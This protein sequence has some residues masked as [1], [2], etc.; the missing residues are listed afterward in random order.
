[1][2]QT[3]AAMGM[4]GCGITDHGS[5]SGA[6]KFYK[7]CKKVG[8]NPIVGI[9]GYFCDNSLDPHKGEKRYHIVL[10]AK[11]FKGFQSICKLMTTAWERMYYVPRMDLDMLM[12]CEDVIVSSACS[13]G[14]LTHPN[15]KRLVGIL[16][17][18]FKDDLYLEIMPLQFPQQEVTNKV[19]I[20]LSESLGVKLIATNDI[21]YLNE[22]DKKIHNFLL[23][24]NT[25][26]SLK[27]EIEGLYLKTWMEMWDT[28]QSL[29]YIDKDI[30]YSA[31]MNTHEVSDK[32]QLDIPER[33]ISL[34]RMDDVEQV[35]LE[36]LK[37]KLRYLYSDGFIDRRGYEDRLEYEFNIIEERG[38]IDYFNL[39][40]DLVKAAR[41]K[42]IELDPGRG[43]SAGSLIC[44]LLGITGL[45]PIKEGLMFER[46]LNPERIDYPDIDMDFPRSRR[47]EMIEYL[48]ER[49][50]NDRVAN[51]STVAELRPKS[52]MKDT[53]REFKIPPMLANVL[54]KM[55]DNEFDFE[56]NLIN[57]EIL[58]T[59]IESLPNGEEIIEFT[60][61]I[62]GTLR[63]FGT[64]AA[65]VVVAPDK[66]TEFGVLERR[67]EDTCLN[68]D[69][70]DVSHFG[71]V[72][73]DILGLRTLDIIAEAR[74]LIHER[75][76]VDIKW[77]DIKVDDPEIVAEFGKG[78]T[79]G[80]FQ[81]E[82]RNMTYLLKKLYPITTKTTLIDCNALGRPGP[83]DSGMVDSY[84][85]R[86]KEEPIHPES[87]DGYIG[88]ITVD[89]YGII[90]YQEQIIQILCDL[91]G[92]T[93]PQADIIRRIFAK[94]KGD[95][96]E[97]RD[98]FINGCSTTVGMPND[99]ANHLFDH[100][101][102]FSRYGFN[103]SHAAAYTELAL[104]QMWLKINYPIEYMIALY[105]WTE[106]EE[107]VSTFIDECQR[108]NIGIYS[109]DINMSQGDFSILKENIII[110][111][112]AIKGVGNVAVE[113]I[114]EERNKK[115][116]KSL[117]D[118]RI[119]IPKRKANISVMKALVLSG[120]FDNLEE[121]NHK[122]IA[123]FGSDPIPGS[124]DFTDEEKE[125]NKITLMPGIYRPPI[126]P[127]GGLDID[128][129]KLDTL[130]G[131][132]E[133]CDVCKL[134]EAYDKP[135]P[136]EFTEQSKI[137]VVAEAPG[138]DEW[139]QGRP[140]IGK[141]GQ[142]VEKLF[143][144]H[145]ITR[146]ELY[147]TNVFKCRPWSNKL[148]DNCPRD[149]YM[150]LEKEI[151]MT[152]PKMILSLGGTPM[153]F[154]T[155]SKQGIEGRADKLK[156]SLEVIDGKTLVNVLY[157]VHPASLFYGNG[158]A[159][160]KRLEDSIAL[161]AEVYFG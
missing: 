96:E 23:K 102:T 126:P 82:S 40:Y 2:V 87:Y 22:E 86:Y 114:I 19:A 139:R 9:E 148:P 76:G 129:Y 100:L 159:N 64:H 107:K 128:T 97:H 161:I 58:R 84:V 106:E 94:K 35:T 66:I 36:M 79:A 67:K 134:R 108:M 63:Q 75:H 70:N 65:G 145:G 51:I 156:F 149:C 78:H 31:L 151:H 17:D 27:F 60:K 52:A 6:I 125:L 157:S 110:G 80:I 146:E 123:E 41:S 88:G 55:V 53:M 54:S 113:A 72:K 121:I 147:L 89:T 92:Y 68:W 34:P 144:Y 10:I 152:K 109:P 47:H 77:E 142:V 138:E 150:W 21:H 155:G 30:F 140:L 111:L 133:V 61:G 122:N 73:V 90:I 43:S 18:R 105:K 141:A 57:N 56:D 104:R 62:S 13:Y 91:A 5:I 130:R 42:N 15:A 99:V 118:F 83:L 98:A 81:F 116:F 59:E 12:D 85:K 160:R 71:L 143:L 33:S 29:N 20:E 48:K 3:A 39:V 158:A 24:I 103:K 124:D 127:E 154:F 95:F 49:W 11:S 25:K 46:F 32:C 153:E 38:F 69:M 131:M 7:A 112:R 132:I 26:G 117:G 50:G 1:M 135:T 120:C 14:I 28:F 74:N 136:F 45:D 93:I 119:R 101:E 37:D 16:Q 4:K 115:L 137:M 8:I 44:Y